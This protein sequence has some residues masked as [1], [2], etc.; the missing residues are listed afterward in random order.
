M[1]KILSVCLAGFATLILSGCAGGD[2]DDRLHD[3][4][5]LVDIGVNGMSDVYYECDSGYS[6]FTGFNGDFDFD[7]SGDECTF[8]FDPANDTTDR[9]LFI[10]NGTVGVAGLPYSCTYNT[11]SGLTPYSGITDANGHFSHVWADGGFYINDTCTIR[12]P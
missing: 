2:V 10:D 6:G 11:G 7:S 9:A 12:Y 1:K 3:V 8:Y 5:Y 4:N